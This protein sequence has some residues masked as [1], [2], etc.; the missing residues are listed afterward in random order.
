MIWIEIFENDDLACVYTTKDLMI[1][2]HLCH[3]NYKI[4]HI[5]NSMTIA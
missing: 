5:S 3:K 4:C 1:A 2:F